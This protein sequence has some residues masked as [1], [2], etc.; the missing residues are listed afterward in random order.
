MLEWTWT[1]LVWAGISAAY[2]PTSAPNI[3]SPAALPN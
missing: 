1:L 2:V 3:T